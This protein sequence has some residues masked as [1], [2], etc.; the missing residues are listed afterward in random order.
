MG[1]IEE[2]PHELVRIETGASVRVLRAK[3]DDGRQVTVPRANV[4]LL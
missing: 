2:L 3:L 4:E 1:V